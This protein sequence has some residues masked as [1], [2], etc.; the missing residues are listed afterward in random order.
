MAS[1]GQKQWIIVCDVEGNNPGD[2]G[3]PKNEGEQGTNLGG[4][5]IKLSDGSYQGAREVGRV[6]FNRTVPKDKSDQKVAFK[7]Q[8]E[9]YLNVANDAAKVLNDQEARIAKLLVNAGE[10]H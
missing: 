6:A 4:V 7:V 8:L 10:M 2:S 5:I 1:Q 9:K 3:E